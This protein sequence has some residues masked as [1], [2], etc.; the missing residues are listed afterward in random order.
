MSTLGRV[1]QALGRYDQAD[2]IHRDILEIRTELGDLSEGLGDYIQSKQYFQESL[3]LSKGGHT[4]Y[5]LAGPG[6]SALGLGEH[7]EATRYFCA[8]QQAAQSQRTPLVL[9]CVTGI[10][11]LL[12]QSGDLVGTTELLAL[13]L[14]NPVSYR[15]TKDRVTNLYTELVAELPSE[16]VAMARK[17]GKVTKLSLVVTEILDERK[18]VFDKK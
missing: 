1:E 3:A 7:Q 5:T 4:G 17:R 10:V 13:V 12:A 15:E 9:D 8:L 2:T 11:Y 6:W 14:V 16:V 18:P